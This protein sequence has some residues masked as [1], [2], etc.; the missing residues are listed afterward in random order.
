MSAAGNKG[1]EDTETGT[2]EM[3]GWSLGA[4]SRELGGGNSW[5]SHNF[6]EDFLFLSTF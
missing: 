6:P 5:A 1:K 2:Q 3:K 4:T